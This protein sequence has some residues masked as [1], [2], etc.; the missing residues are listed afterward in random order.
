MESKSDDVGSSTPFAIISSSLLDA[1]G[2]FVFPPLPVAVWRP[3]TSLS[4]LYA[5]CRRDR[6]NVR[7]GGYHLVWT[8]IL[9][10]SETSI[11]SNMASP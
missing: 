10:N 7:E 8:N 11:S 5:K 9:V 2:T 6:E 4:I 1:T 3:I